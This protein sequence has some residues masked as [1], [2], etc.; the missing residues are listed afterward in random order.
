VRSLEDLRPRS[1]VGAVDVGDFDGDGRIDLAV[2]YLSNELGDWHTGIDLFFNRPGAQGWERK[3][4]MAENGRAWLT[5]L[6][7]GDLDGDG[8]LDLAALT[9]DGRTLVFLGDGKGR[10]TREESPE[11]PVMQGAC[12]G[13]DVKIRNLDDDPAGELVEEFAGEP[14]ALFAPDLCPTQG[15]ILA[16]K[17][18]AGAG[19]DKKK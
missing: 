10:F 9:G 11:I 2:G 8:K 5:A 14:S 19:K 15:A 12:R 4:L 16:W 6:G 3:G 7:A 18:R 1:Y 13:Y 17:A